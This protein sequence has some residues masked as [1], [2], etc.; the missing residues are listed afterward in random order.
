MNKMIHFKKLFNNE[1]SK[2]KFSF[3]QTFDNA[4]YDKPCFITLVKSNAKP[5][6]VNPSEQCIVHV[7]T[8]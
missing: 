5:S 3:E 8:N 6:K 7:V 1:Q 4:I 2:Y